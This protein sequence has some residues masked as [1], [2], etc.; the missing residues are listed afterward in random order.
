M[1]IAHIKS[2]RTHKLIYT[3]SNIF[4]TY[5]QLIGKVNKNTLIVGRLLILLFGGIISD[6]ELLFDA[7]A[8]MRN[9][10]PYIYQEKIMTGKSDNSFDMDLRDTTSINSIQEKISLYQISELHKEINYL[11]RQLSLIP[12][13]VRLICKY[14][15]ELLWTTSTLLGLGWLHD[16]SRMRAQNTTSTPTITL[17][18]VMPSVM[19]SDMPTPRLFLDVTATYKSK[20]NTGVQRVI[21]E[22]CRYGKEGGEL[23]PVIINEGRFVT[24]PSLIPVPFQDGDLLLLLDSS[25]TLTNIYPSALE[26][27]RSQGAE[28]ILG[29]Y[30]LI[31]IQY[32]GFVQPA[33]TALFD[34]WLRT[35]TPFCT[36]ALAISKYSA[37]SFHTWAAINSNLNSI[38]QIGW[39]HLG[40]DLP[41]MNTEMDTEYP[42]R[43][44][45]PSIYLLSVGTIEPRKGYSVSLDAFDILWKA[46]SSLA[47]V[48]IGRHGDLASHLVE[49]ITNHEQFGKKLFWPQN[50][51]DRQLAKYYEKCSA[52]VIPALAEGFGLPLIEASHHRKPIIASD[53]PVFKEIAP[54]DVT[55]FSTENSTELANAIVTKLDCNVPPKT[56]AN[57]DWQTAT[58]K[59]IKLIKNN[60]YQINI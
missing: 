29:I 26:A 32:P 23:A 40:A 56:P 27:A 33:F 43:N 28:I 60:A 54:E 52:L 42:K 25:W 19:P 7:D 58:H 16:G 22:L 4:W 10:Y 36:A 18:S 21:R 12:Q 3:T 15:Q 37:E 14:T 51:D 44:K 46:G 6:C 48:I 8:E 55:F 20:I 5:R 17:P 24:I 11:K 39:F 35:I 31:P 45:L 38:K 50:V 59:L 53:L 34:A 9:Y 30:D 13:P 1:K 41:K 57:L 2:I 49:R 47:Y